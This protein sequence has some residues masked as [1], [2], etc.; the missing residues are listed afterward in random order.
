MLTSTIEG[1]N[2]KTVYRIVVEI[3]AETEGTDADLAELDNESDEGAKTEASQDDQTG[4][5]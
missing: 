5:S 1:S 3:E 4:S 2:F